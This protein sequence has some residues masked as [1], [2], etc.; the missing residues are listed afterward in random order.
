MIRPTLQGDRPAIRLR[1]AALLCLLSALMAARLQAQDLDPRAYARIPVNVTTLITGFAWSH[2]GIVTDP[3]LP[4]E[5]LDATVEAASLAVAHSFRLFGRTAQAFAT[6]PPYSWARASALVGGQPES[7]TRSGFSDMR[8][9]LSVLMVGAPALTAREFANAPHRTVLG[10]SLTVLA[11]TGQNYPEKLINLGARRWA[12]KP[13]VALS[14]P[15]SS[16]WLLDIYTGVW[17]FTRNDAFYP[18][19]SVRTQEPL[20]TVQAHLSYN[21]RP[22]AWAALDATY[23]TGG[24][25]TVNGAWNDDRQA[26]SRI[27]ATLV[28]PVKQRHSVKLAVSTGAVVRVGARFTTLSIGWQTS[29][30]RR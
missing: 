16:R 2:G 22:R 21:L 11:P 27:G 1:P 9:R 24:Q 20:G 7:V 28:L 15:F 19:T 18:G 6:V 4:L 25:S 10:A 5:N 30:A 12:V 26:N 17:F 29:W 3:T 14:Q 13:E 23:Y 8:V